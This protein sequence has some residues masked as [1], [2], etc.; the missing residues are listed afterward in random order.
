MSD[1]KEKT[2]GVVYFLAWV[3]AFVLW[4]VGAVHSSKHGDTLVCVCVPPYAWYRGVECFFHS[5]A[6]C[7]Q[8]VGKRMVPITIR[9]PRTGREATLE[10]TCP[11]CGGKGI[12]IEGD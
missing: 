12:E 2:L 8:C 6:Q 9:D 4:I 11:R 5:P 7:P 1:W 10:Q 3:L